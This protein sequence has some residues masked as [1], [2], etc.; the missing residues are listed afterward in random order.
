MMTLRTIPAPSTALSAALVAAALATPAVAADR[1]C[2]SLQVRAYPG[3]A[4]HDVRAFLSDPAYL[5]AIRADLT[6][7]NGTEPVPGVVF[8]TAQTP[9]TEIV[10]VSLVGGEGA[11]VQG[12]MQAL[13]DHL[14][15]IA[16]SRWEE[17]E[18]RV[19]SARERVD[20]ADAMLAAAASRRLEYLDAHGASNPGQALQTTLQDLMIRRRELDNARSNLAAAEALRGYLVETLSQYGLTSDERATLERELTALRGELEAQRA[21][22]SAQHPLV[23]KVQ[24]KLN[25]AEARLA[26][27]APARDAED[28]EQQRRNFEGELFGAERELAMTR[29]QIVQLEATVADLEDRARELAKRDVEWA[30]VED[31]FRDAQRTAG[32]AR[33][34]LLQAEREYGAQAAAPW[35]RVLAGPTFGD[36]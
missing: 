36:A 35:L 7:A 14:A 16:P 18:H 6:N 26:K 3:Y 12:G 28:L 27:A 11:D 19:A 13:L 2:V 32:M 34:A 23:V 20:L 22:K 17:E 31:T 10:T 5:G 21:S 4:A 15:T 33:E 1:C 8:V 24:E 9:G 30:E 25:A 29:S